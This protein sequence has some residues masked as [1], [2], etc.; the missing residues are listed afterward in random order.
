MNPIVSFDTNLTKYI[1]SWPTWL[2]PGMNFVTFLG[3][4]VVIVL[5]AAF[6]AGVAWRQHQYRVAQGFIVAVAACGLN[7][8]VKYFV[9]R[10]RPDTIYVTHMRFKS[11]SF[12]SGHAFGSLLLYGLLA[13]LAFKHLPSPWNLVAVAA[14]GILIFAIGISRVYLGAHFPTDVIAGWILAGIALWLIIK[15]F[16]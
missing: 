1:Q 10:T 11:Y 7:G 13:Y 16:F 6:A 3:E 12:P 9:H 8:A 2:Q 4:P 5:V 15:Y 14:A